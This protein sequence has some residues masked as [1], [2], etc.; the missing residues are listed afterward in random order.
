MSKEEALKKALEALLRSRKAVA[1]DYDLASCAYGSNDPD[2]HR[3]QDAKKT[4]ESV[5]EAITAI[6]QALAAPVQEPV[7]WINAKGDMTYLHGPYNSDD[8]P[9]IYGDTTPPA[10]PV[11]EPEIDGATIA[12]MNASIGHLSALVD[13]LRLLLGCAMDNFKMLHNAAKPDDGPDMDAIIPAIV[14]AK[15][16]NQDAA[17]RYAIKH[18]AHDGTITAPPAAQPVS[19]P[20]LTHDQWDAWQ[21]KHGLILERDA[22]DDLRSMLAA[23]PAPTVQE[24]VAWVTVEDGKCISTRSAD[25]RHIT[26]GQYQLYVGPLDYE[27]PAAIKTLESLGYI[28]EEGEQWTAPPAAPVQE[29]VAWRWTNGKGWLTYGEAPHDTFKSTPLYTAPPAAQ[30]VIPDAMTSADIQEHI[31]YVAGWNECRQAMLE[32]MK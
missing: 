25:F 32:M 29:P 19:V 26:D 23:Q 2:G 16:V 7:A 1:G 14:F 5:K 15:F 12:G 13:E 30:P 27:V 8:R 21:D 22:L 20:D 28:Y 4:V 17:L 31:E 10:A 11:Q 6:K 3:Y 24:P 18:S 9:L